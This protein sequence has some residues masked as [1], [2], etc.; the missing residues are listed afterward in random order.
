[1]YCRNCGSPLNPNLWV[2][3]RCS[4][5]NGF[6]NQFCPNCGNAVL[7]DAVTC[8]T[9]GCS[10]AKTQPQPQQAQY[11]QPQYQQAQYQ[12]PQYQQTQYQQ[13]PQIMPPQPT[14]QNN[15]QQ[16]YNQ[17]QYNN[18]QMNARP[19]EQKS[20]MTAVILALFLGGLGTHNFYLGYT[21]KAIAQLVIYLISIPL[22]AVVIG[23]FTIF[24]PGTWAFIEMILLLTG[25]I[26]TDGNG[27]PLKD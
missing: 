7:P 19:L 8:G 12:Q 27:L 2:C 25:S 26:N 17:N 18:Q 21:N 16:N 9:C 24:I 4:A 1:M 23:F 3:E 13:P 20:K 11:Q 14:Y 15:Y 6:G 5:E 10:L 22:M